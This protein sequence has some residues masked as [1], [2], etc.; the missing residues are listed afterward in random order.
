MANGE[1]S[2]DRCAPG[3]EQTQ[4][5]LADALSIDPTPYLDTIHAQYKPP[6]TVYIDTKAC[7]GCTKC[8]PV[9]PVGAIS[10]A[11]KHLHQVIDHACTGCDLCLAA[12][13][14]DCMHPKEIDPPHDEEAIQSQR[15]YFKAQH[16]ITTRILSSRLEEKKKR[17]ERTK[18]Q[19]N[20][21]I[22]RIKNQAKS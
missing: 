18:T 14:V 15:A 8:I 17:Y 6:S 4:R 22:D 7:I 3:G 19:G 9:C 1:V 11:P 2:I 10:G 12:C 5:D 20:S 16:E 21:L 13:P